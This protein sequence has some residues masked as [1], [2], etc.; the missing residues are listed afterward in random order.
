[1]D[2]RQLKYFI[3]IAEEGSL[4]AASARLNVAQPSLSHHVI[5]VEREL[6]V[7]LVKRSPRGVVLTESGQTLLKHARE[8]CASMDLCRDRV[9][10]CGGKPKGEVTVG[11]PSS[12]SMMLSVPLIETVLFE[13]PQIKLRIVEAMSGFI[14]G[15]LDDQTINLAFLYEVSELKHCE[16]TK[17]MSEELYFFAAPDNWPWSKPPG[18][19]VT[20]NE[21]HELDLILPSPQHGLRQTLERHADARGVPLNVI[22]EMDSLAQIKELVVRGSG[23]TILAPAAANDRVRRGELV[24][25]RIV[26]PIISRPVYLVRNHVKR[27][28]DACE[29]V[30]RI[31]LDVVEDLVRRKIW[32]VAEPSAEGSH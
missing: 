12:V 19:S 9:R 15:W 32:L 3:A 22:I 14:R 11:M 10:L 21:I 8:I 23:Y 27:M 29:V 16:V 5:K 25:S 18:A 2:I 28:T 1:V 24:M 26:E 4:S 31:A 6:G 20:L 7:T 17:L 30:E 13:Q